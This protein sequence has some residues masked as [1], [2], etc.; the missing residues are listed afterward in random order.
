MLPRFSRYG[1]VEQ[2]GYRLS[3]ALAAKGHQVDFLCARQEVAAPEGVRVRRT[4]RPF[5]PRWLKMLIFAVRAEAL[6]RNGDY[7]CTVSLGKTLNQD[8]MR[9]G[10][11]PLTEFWRYSERA[12]PQ[13]LTRAF[14]RL[15]RRLSPGN[16]LTL[17][18]ERRQYAR[19]PV[20]IAVSHFVRDLIVTSRP[21]LDPA[22][23]RI[24]YNRPDLARFS[25]PTFE[26]RE[27]ARRVFGIK[28]GEIAIGL[29]TSNFA[30]K[31]VEPLIRALATLPET[32]S[33]YVAGGRK[34]A[35][36]DALA[37]RLGVADRVRFLG[38]VDSMP[39]WYRA[40]DIFT[41]PS[42]YDACSNAVL[43]ALASGL[44]VLSS[45][46]NGSSVFL[47]PE[48]V[49]DDPGDPAELARVLTRLISDAEAAGSAGT[50]PRF[51]WPEGMVSGL[52]A[53]VEMVEEAAKKRMA[54]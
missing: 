37:L 7:D 4:G 1:G 12:Y 49:V 38:K 42:F 29:A 53:F 27:D 33:L 26:Q 19:T 41:L 30:L 32:C 11:G 24:V 8:V 50:R 3:A 5:G 13:G 28:D 45:A 18:I 31:G 51:Q 21:G 17:L 46:S 47:P 35:A 25:P 16:L 48:N 6:R 20:I 44:P 43:E 52:D 10:G 34:H 15:R 9:V 40:I 14:K 36:Y 54:K 23:I 2:F 22:S 39:D